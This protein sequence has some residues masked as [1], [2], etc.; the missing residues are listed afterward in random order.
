M[1]MT[2]PFYPTTK[3]GK[4]DDLQFSVTSIFSELRCP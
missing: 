1:C 2:Q 4:V 3:A